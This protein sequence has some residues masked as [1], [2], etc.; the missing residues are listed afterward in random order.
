MS[1]LKHISKVPDNAILITADVAG[2]YPSIPYNEGLEV[3]KKQLDKFYEKLIPT[4]G[5]VEM[6]E[7]VLKNNYLEFDSNV[8][9]QISRTAIGT[10]FAPPYACIYIYGV[11]G[12]SVSQK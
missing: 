4:E 3:L 8:K 2:L 9:H 11:H 7:F 12:E 5:L 10:K 1:K 6:T